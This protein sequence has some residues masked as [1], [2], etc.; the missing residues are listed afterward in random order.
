MLDIIKILIAV[1]I[2]GVTS[3]RLPSIIKQVHIRRLYLLEESR[4]TNWPK[5]LLLKD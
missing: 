1:A 4:A 2:F 3:M 5:A